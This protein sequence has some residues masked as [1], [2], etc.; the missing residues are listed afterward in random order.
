MGLDCMKWD[1]LDCFAQC[2][3]CSHPNHSVPHQ[4]VF[5]PATPTPLLPIKGLA[6]ELMAM[7]RM[8]M[9]GADPLPF[10]FRPGYNENGKIEDQ[11]L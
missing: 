8:T 11:V 2:F 5:Q 1:G 10:R 9:R 4:R 7:F 6:P 3:K